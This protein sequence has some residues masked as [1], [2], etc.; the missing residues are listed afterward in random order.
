MSGL[1]LEND[2]AFIEDNG[3]ISFVRSNEDNNAYLIKNNGGRVNRTVLEFDDVHDM[4]E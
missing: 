3:K 1:A 2:I 4:P